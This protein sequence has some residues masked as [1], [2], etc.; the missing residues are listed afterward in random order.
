MTAAVALAGLVL[1]GPPVA[2]ETIRGTL[3][4][5]DGGTLPGGAEIIVSVR[6]VSGPGRLGRT[7]TEQRF[8]ADGGSNQPFELNFPTPAASAVNGYALSVRVLYRGRLA[9]SNTERVAIDPAQAGAPV[10]VPLVAQ[11]GAAS[12]PAVVRGPAQPPPRS[13]EPAQAV[14]VALPAEPRVAVA[15]DAPAE[16]PPPPAAKPVEAATAPSVL[17][18]VPAEAKAPDAPAAAPGALRCVGNEPGWLLIVHGPLARL[19]TQDPRVPELNMPA[20][21]TSAPWAETP[22]GVLRAESREAGTLVAFITAEACA[23]SMSGEES[24]LRARVSMPDGSLRAGCCRPVMAAADPRPAADWSRLLPDLLPVV[25]AC[26]GARPGVV[27]AAWPMNRGKAGVR[28]GAPDGER[29]D[30]LG[31]LASA[32]VER[33][34]AVSNGHR[35]P[36]EGQPTLRIGQPAEPQACRKIEA[37][38]GPNGDA[39]GSLAWE[40]CR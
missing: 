27:L 37:V 10:R 40:A 39:V 38:T 14:A 15:R 29:F 3:V 30:C 11:A 26:A 35:L 18:A 21:Y 25:Q 36:N 5:R 9:W 20:R 1:G 7:L 17:A 4:P 19:R 33:V 28:I 24:P 6:E 12:V 16:V 23:D 13:R 22:F 8:R 32:R 34:A 2:A 31:D